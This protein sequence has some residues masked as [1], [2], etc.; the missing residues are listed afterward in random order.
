MS[1]LTEKLE[2]VRGNDRNIWPAPF[3]V[4]IRQ[5]SERLEWQSGTA[6]EVR[7]LFAA[8]VFIRDPADIL[9]VQILDAKRHI[10]EEVFGEFR[11]PLMLIDVALSEWDIDKAR[12]LLRDL[13]VQMFE[14]APSVD[15]VDPHVESEGKPSTRV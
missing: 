6:Y 13:R 14:L 4:T 8:R 10:V 1:R 15:A 12:E 2:A 11:R 9:P 7:A 5:Q 3:G